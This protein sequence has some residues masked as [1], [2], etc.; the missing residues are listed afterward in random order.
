MVILTKENKDSSEPFALMEIP[1]HQN[2]F[3]NTCFGTSHQKTLTL[4]KGV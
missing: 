3:L 2:Q 4:G 1:L